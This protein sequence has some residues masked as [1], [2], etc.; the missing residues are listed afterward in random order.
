MSIRSTQSGFTILETLVAILIFSMSV[1][2]IFSLL[3]ESVYQG[4]FGK[5]DITATYLAQEGIDFV[6]N[7]RDG[8]IFQQEQDFGEFINL[9]S[10][11]TII[12]C[13][14]DLQSF[15]QAFSQCPQDRCPLLEFSTF[16]TQP[17]IDGNTVF[18]R[19][20]RSYIG[21]INDTA[22][23]TIWVTVSWEDAGSIRAKTYTTTFYD[24]NFYA[25]PE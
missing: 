19:S 10:D 2:A 8:Y 14:I 7:I 23:I 20:L 17:V 4:R 21:D 13:A 16:Y 24:L 1:T 6:K 11:C 12:P 25:L 3:R 5:N 22:F 18:R 15:P 9:V